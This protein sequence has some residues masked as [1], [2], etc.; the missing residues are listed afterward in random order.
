MSLHTGEEQE[1]V[2]QKAHFENPVT[3]VNT[4]ALKTILRHVKNGNE[5]E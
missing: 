5:D 1:P 2:T 4:S 3:Q